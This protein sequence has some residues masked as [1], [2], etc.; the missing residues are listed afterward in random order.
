MLSIIIPAQNEEEVIENTIRVF[1]KVLNARK[2]KHEILVVNDHSEDNTLKILFKLEK[3]IKEL[4]HIDNLSSNGFGTTIIQGLNNFEGDYVTIV[5]ADLSDDPHDLIRYYDKI[6]KGYDCV[7]GSRFIKGGKVI[8][9]PKFKLILNRLGNN[10]MR[11]LFWIKY[12]DITNPFKLYSRETID[13]IKP[14]ISRHFNLEV[15]IPLKAIVRGYTYT[16]LPNTW[17]NRTKGLA[18][19]K[20]IKMGV[21]YFIIILYCFIEKS[22]KNA[23]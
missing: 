20:I 18:K 21:G 19:F 12:N 16:V 23:S 4:R 22:L 3:E 10:F 17:K 6:K 7:F 2:I 11:L 8:N 14:L 1:N 13:G 5:M 9:Y 15:E